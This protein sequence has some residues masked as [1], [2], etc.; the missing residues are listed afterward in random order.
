MQPQYAQRALGTEL[1]QQIYSQPWNSLFESALGYQRNLIP[2]CLLFL[3]L[4]IANFLPYFDPIQV[5][6]P[7]WG[8]GRCFQ[9]GSRSISKL[10]C[11]FSWFLLSTGCWYRYRADIFY[12]NGIKHFLVVNYLLKSRFGFCNSAEMGF[13]LF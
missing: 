3:Y 2:S 12:A 10:E 1:L 4:E 5:K 9:K 11:P 8:E 13:H 7:K 6:R